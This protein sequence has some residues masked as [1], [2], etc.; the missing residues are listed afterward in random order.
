MKK[1]GLILLGFVL[2]SFSQLMAQ[3]YTAVE[4]WK[5]EQDP[6][7]VQLLQRQNA[8]EILTLQEQNT[9]VEY[10]NSLILYFE[11]LS[12]N[13]K[14][15]YYKNRTKWTEQR[16]TKDKLTVQQEIDVYAGERSKYSQYLF[17]SGFFGLFY[18]GAAVSIFNIEGGAAAA[19]PLLTAGASTLVPML[20]IKDKNVSYNSLALSNHGKVI[21]ALQGAAFGL[22]LTG[23]NVDEGKLILGLSTLSSIGLG[24]LGYI[25]GR[26]KPWSQG[27]VA[28]YA[29]YGFLMPLEGLALVI[30]FESEQPRMYAASSL[31]FGAAG[32]LIADK[33]SQW[34]DFTR[35][36]ITATSTLSTLNT[37]LGFC[38]MTDIAEQYNTK[39]GDLMIPAIGALGGTLAGH[40]WLKDARL[41][42]QQGWNTALATAGGALIGLGL[43]A[44]F[45]PD[46]FTPYYIVSYATGL[47]SY[48]IL[49]SQYKKNNSLALFEQEKKSRWDINLMPQSIFLNKKIAS[50]AFSN[51]GKRINFLPA[52]SATLNF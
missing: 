38:I 29:H 20:S 44:L 22:L 30:A 18:G 4:Y 9:L 40:L 17:T 52:F 25:L 32:Y 19:I 42:N 36:D 33:V 15:L 8:G 12:D 35:G 26:D 2:F 16:G 48:A 31:A 34:N 41:T 37:Y 46:S 51:P 6:V 43:T 50:Y 21:G 45:T 23:D 3:N 39:P 28:L 27:R 47:S 14:S 10:R 5:M 24:R 11:K 7:Y 49:L 1:S 13:E